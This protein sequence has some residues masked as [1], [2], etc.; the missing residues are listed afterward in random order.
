MVFMLAGWVFFRENPLFLLPRGA[1][2]A[3]EDANRSLPESNDP[4][5]DSPQLA[6]HE[7]LAW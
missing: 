7:S 2:C 6:Q 1:G 5:I 3:A 4:R